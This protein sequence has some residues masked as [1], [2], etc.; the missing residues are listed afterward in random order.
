MCTTFYFI[1]YHFWRINKVNGRGTRTTSIAQ[2]ANKY[3]N[4]VAL[5]YLILLMALKM[6]DPDLP[7]V[8]VM[9]M[10]TLF[11]KLPL[12][13]RN[14]AHQMCELHLSGHV[15]SLVACING[16]KAD[17][18]RAIDYFATA[19]GVDIRS[20]STEALWLRELFKLHLNE[21]IV[22]IN[23]KYKSV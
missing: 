3:P 14:L 8:R 23:V 7:R 12:A 21:L 9:S 22:W 15:Y 4:R 18:D 11:A 6:R 17:G 1:I 16:V 13:V 19:Y 10:S 20:G 5:S 2:L